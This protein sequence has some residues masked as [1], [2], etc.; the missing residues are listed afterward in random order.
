MNEWM[1]FDFDDGE[2]T[3][4]FETPEAWER[5]IAEQG[6]KKIALSCFCDY[7]TE[8]GFEPPRFGLR[9]SEYHHSPSLGEW[10]K[11]RGIRL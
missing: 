1:P 7:P 9:T 6:G 3:H 4:L 11:K 10:A 8:R 5:W 2:T